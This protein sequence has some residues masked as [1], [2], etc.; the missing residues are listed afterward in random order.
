MW[1]IIVPGVYFAGMFLTY[2]LIRL[3][4]PGNAADDK[5][6]AAIWPFVLPF[7]LLGLVAAFFGYLLDQVDPWGK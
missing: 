4:D 6:M 7:V 1:W 2:W 5:S 3:T